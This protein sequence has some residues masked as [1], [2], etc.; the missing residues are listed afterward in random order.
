MQVNPNWETPLAVRS[1]IPLHFAPKMITRLRNLLERLRSSL[2]VLPATLT[3]G[4]AIL[5]ELALLADGWIQRETLALPFLFPGSLEGAR[6][7]LGALVGS[8]VSLTTI[9]FS[10]MMVVLTLASNQFGP[11]VVRNFLSDRLN[12]VTLGVFVATFVYCL[13]VLGRLP[14]PQEGALSTPRLAVT[15]ALALT[16]ASLGMLISFIHHVACSIQASHVVLRAHHELQRS[17][18]TIYPEALGEDAPTRDARRRELEQDRAFRVKMDRPG[19]IQAITT[20]GVMAFA[21]ERDAFV[22]LLVKPGQFVTGGDEVA[23]VSFREGG[24]DAETERVV[25]GWL[26]LGAERTGE[27]DA[28]YGFRQI[29]EVA[30]RALSPSINDPSTAVSCIDYIGANLDELAM[31]RFADPERADDDGQIRVIGP[32]DGFPEIAA[33]AVDNLR[34][35]ARGH[36]EVMMHLAR[37]LGSLGRRVRRPDDAAWTRAALA[38]LRAE[39]EHLSAPVDRDRFCAVCDSARVDDDTLPD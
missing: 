33:A 10:I 3:L 4:A 9:S 25:R 7:V 20:D 18:N 38:A 14:E 11:R 12:Q 30:L 39:A 5:S 35:Y 28:Q 1:A 36:P 6:Q 2:W 22:R 31:R 27:Q 19:Y 29:S 13:L 26:V 15:L 21:E 34:C 24:I 23:E 32:R 17:I 37:M 16:L 8:M